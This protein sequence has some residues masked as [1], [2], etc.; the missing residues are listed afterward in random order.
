MQK[1]I[2]NTALFANISLVEQK[3]F[4]FSVSIKENIL[5]G[6]DFGKEQLDEVIKVCALEEMVRQYGLE[7]EIDWN[8]G[9]V[10]GGELQRITIART[11][12]R[13]PK[14]LLLDEITASLD[15]KTAELIAKNIVAFTK[16]YNI[17]IIAVSHKDE[18]IPFSNKK[19]VF[20]QEN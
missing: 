7:K 6:N 3:P 1:E 5:L 4:L 18:F 12:I 10:S 14:F 17:G 11:L 2:P 16:K 8:G 15:A 9:N 19:I 20:G 13:K